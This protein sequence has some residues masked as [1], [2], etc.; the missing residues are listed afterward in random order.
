MGRHHLSIPKLQRW[1]RWS[2][3][4]SCIVDVWEWVSNFIPYLLGDYLSMLAWK[5][6]RVNKSGPWCM[7]SQL[8]HYRP[9][10]LY[11]RQGLTTF[12]WPEQRTV[13]FEKIVENQDYQANE[14]K[15]SVIG[16]INTNFPSSVGVMKFRIQHITGN[17]M[18][19]SWIDISLYLLK[20]NA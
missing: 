13:V 9:S 1:N 4:I 18:Q 16:Q 11:F 14:Y 6:I 10:R 19:H 7:R 2:L 5:L 17:L 15:F 8:Q 12:I 20:D 3:K